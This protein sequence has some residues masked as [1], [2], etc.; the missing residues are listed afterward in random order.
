VF[1]QPLRLLR[2]IRSFLSP[3]CGLLLPLSVFP[4]TLPSCLHQTGRYNRQPPRAGT[5]SFTTRGLHRGASAGAAAPAAKCGANGTA[6]AVPALSAQGNGG[7]WN[8]PGVIRF[9]KG[10][11]K[12]S[13]LSID[14]GAWRL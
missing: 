13:Q 14:V 7:W 11:P 2:A 6:H 9:P 10:N 12:S 1:L 3:R 8:R 5:G 4:R